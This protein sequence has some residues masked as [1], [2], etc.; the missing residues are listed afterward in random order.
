MA[1]RT[2]TTEIAKTAKKTAPKA[3]RKTPI[4]SR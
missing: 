3:A 4:R 1:K 2:V